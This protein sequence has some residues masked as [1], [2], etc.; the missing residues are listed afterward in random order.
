MHCVF[1]LLLADK[2][3][4]QFFAFARDALIHDG[5]LRCSAVCR[6]RWL[7]RLDRAVDESFWR[8]DFI[9]F[10][11][12]SQAIEKECVIVGDGWPVLCF[13]ILGKESFLANDVVAFGVRMSGSSEQVSD[14]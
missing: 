14:D 1:V 8:L 13:I 2:S 9:V 10:G 3:A 6:A 5:A 11:R 12:C 7:A 4:Q